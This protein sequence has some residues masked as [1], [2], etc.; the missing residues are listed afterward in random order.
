MFLGVVPCYLMLPL[1]A[2]RQWPM[3]LVPLL[4]HLCLVLSMGN[5][6]IDGPPSIRP[7]I[8]M[9]VLTACGVWLAASGG[10]AK[11]VAKTNRKNF[12]R[13]LKRSQGALSTSQR[14]LTHAGHGSVQAAPG[15]SG[16]RENLF[17]IWP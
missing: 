16:M 3:G 7:I 15:R 10:V 13:I 8:I 4:V 2:S 1:R 12:S 6:Y 17:S 9:V 14:K 11:I 5:P